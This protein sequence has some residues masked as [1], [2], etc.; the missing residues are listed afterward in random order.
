MEGVIYLE[1][2]RYQLADLSV[3]FITPFALRTCMKTEYVISGTT[4]GLMDLNYCY[5]IS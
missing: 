5:K 3:A 1:A 4:R 2:D